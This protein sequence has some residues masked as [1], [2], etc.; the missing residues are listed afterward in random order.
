MDGFFMNVLTWIGIYLAV[1]NLLGFLFMGID[2]W[3]AVNHAW[4][5]P[6]AS[7][8][9]IALIGGSIGS[10]LGMQLFRHKTKHW[11]F[12]WGMPAI[13]VCQIL[14]VFFLLRGTWVTIITI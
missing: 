11:Y 4:R 1:V 14:L 10:I 7:L 13:L 2:K 12:V 9:L 3:K 8:F 5:I 6:E